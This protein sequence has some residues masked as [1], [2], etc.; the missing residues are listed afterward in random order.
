MEPNTQND[1]LLIELTA[2]IVSAYFGNHVV[3]IGEIPGI[4]KDVHAALAANRGGEVAKVEDD[5]VTKPVPAV[6]VNKSIDKKGQYIICLEDGQK[7]RSLKRHLKTK[8]NLTPAEYREKWNLPADYP[9]V[10]PTYAEARSRLAKE[11][12]LGRGRNA[13]KQR[14]AA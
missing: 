7:Y 8:Y 10:A 14:Q 4:I 2:D 5:V 12:G 11:M 6:P 13:D 1:N 3:P 9:M